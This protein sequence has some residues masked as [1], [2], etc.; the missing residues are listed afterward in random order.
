[1]SAAEYAGPPVSLICNLAFPEAVQTDQYTIRI[2]FRMAGYLPVVNAKIDSTEGTFIFDTGAERLLL[3]KRYFQ[4]D[5]SLPGHVQKGVTGGDED[6]LIKKVD[7]LVWENLYLHGL[8]ANVLDLSHIETKR[9]LRLVGII[10]YDVFKDYEVMVDYFSQLLT[11]TKLDENGNRLDK[12]AFPDQPFDSLDFQLGRHGIVVKGIVAGE[13]LNLNIDTGAEINLLDRNVPKKVLKH[14]KVLKRVT[15]LG[16]G[17]QEVEVLAGTL[18]NLKC[19]QQP[20]GIMKTLLTN[21][22]DL[23]DI[24]GMHIDGVLG[25]EFLRPR[26]TLINYTRR[27]LYFFKPVNP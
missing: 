11:L 24:F 10:G 19:G 5:G 23:S 17:Q 3:N 13:T 20:T 6:I 7:T 2:P 27:K 14:F 25:Y 21:T 12:K 4:P 16:A 26:R 9:N 1:M 18:I 22:D 8:R 15:L